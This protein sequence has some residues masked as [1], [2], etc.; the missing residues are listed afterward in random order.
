[1]QAQ[2]E[3]SFVVHPIGHVEKKEARTVIVLDKKYQAG[4]LGLDVWSHVQAFW[5]FD[6]N[7]TPQRRSM[8]QVHLRGVGG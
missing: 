2:Q 5:W 8:P 7:D 1:V 3:Q 4:L 6:K